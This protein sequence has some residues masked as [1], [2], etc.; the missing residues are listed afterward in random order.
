MSPLP[1]RA[2]DAG[3]EWPEEVDEAARDW[4]EDHAPENDDG[5]NP[6]N[7]DL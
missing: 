6:S 3:P 4:N 1:N 5:W 2:S 7:E